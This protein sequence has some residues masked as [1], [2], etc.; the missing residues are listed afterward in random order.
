MTHQ[1]QLFR[2]RID[3]TVAGY[4]KLF[5]NGIVEY[6]KDQFWWHGN[7][8]EYNQKDLFSGQLDRHNRPLFENDIVAMRTTIKSQPKSNCRLYFHEER[9]SFVLEQ[10]DNQN[11]FELFAGSE[12]IF[13]KN[14]LTFIGFSFNDD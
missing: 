1:F 7:P 3:H 11:I 10:L 6:S 8:I 13:H 5:S 2:L 4:L 12:S 9:G 14:E